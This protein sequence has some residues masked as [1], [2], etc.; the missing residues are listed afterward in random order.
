MVSQSPHMGVYGRVFL[1][2]ESDGGIGKAVLKA[3]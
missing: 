2:G 1:G 3:V